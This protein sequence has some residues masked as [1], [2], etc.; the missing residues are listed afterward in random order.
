[1]CKYDQ[2]AKPTKKVGTFHSKQGDYVKIP[3]ITEGSKSSRVLILLWVNDLNTWSYPNTTQ[4]RSTIQST[5]LREEERNRVDLWNKCEIHLMFFM[6]IAE[7]T[8]WSDREYVLSNW[9]QSL[10]Q[11]EED[12]WTVLQMFVTLCQA[13]IGRDAQA[14][15]SLG[16]YTGYDRIY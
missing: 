9:H 13:L 7:E 10:F 8:L 16:T 5:I 2:R 4:R 15:C 11:E 12:E 6:S 3:S 1:M 14:E